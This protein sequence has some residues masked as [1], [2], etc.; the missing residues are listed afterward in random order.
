MCYGPKVIGSITKC[1]SYD[2][3]IIKTIDEVPRNYDLE[4]RRARGGT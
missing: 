3:M 4:W 2:G 1:A